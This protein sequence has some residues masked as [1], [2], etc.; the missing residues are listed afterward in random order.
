M[1]IIAV[2]SKYFPNIRYKLLLSIP[3]SGIDIKKYIVIFQ[4]E[5]VDS[6]FCRIIY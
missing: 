1:A 6:L 2:K 3:K 4:P 5:F